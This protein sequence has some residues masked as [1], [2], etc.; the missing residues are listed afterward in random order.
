MGPKKVTDVKGRKWMMLSMEIK[1]EIIKKYKADMRLSVIANEYGRNPST[2]GTILKQRE[3]IKAATHFKVGTA[4]SSKMSYIHDEIE[5]LLIVWIKD[6]EMVGDA[7]TEAIICQKVSA[8]FGD[9]VHAEA[10]ADARRRRN[11]EAGTHKVQGFLLVVLKNFRD[12]QAFIWWCVMGRRKLG[13][14][15]GR[16]LC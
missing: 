1:M 11:I 5:R 2:I 12:G 4:F 14:E 7:I 9:L 13:Q 6:K 3:D 15:S 16:S 8:I 10:E